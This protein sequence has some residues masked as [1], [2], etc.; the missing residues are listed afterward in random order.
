MP[1]HA[2]QLPDCTASELLALYARGAASPVEAAQE[3]LARIARLNDSLN[4]FCHLAPDETLAMAREAEQRWRA[5]QP[6]GPL[7][8]VPVSIKD[9]ILTRG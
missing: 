1:A 9:L 3:V 4:A 5:G 7:D 2:S 8:G 6:C